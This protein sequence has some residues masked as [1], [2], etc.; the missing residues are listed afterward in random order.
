ME[1][2]SEVRVV[3]VFVDPR[4]SIKVPRMRFQN[5]IISIFLIS[6]AWFLHEENVVAFTPNAPLKSSGVIGVR[7]Q[8]N[9]QVPTRVFQSSKSLE[10]TGG[11]AVG[12]ETSC[13]LSK[14]EVGSIITRN[15]GT[16]KEKRLNLYGISIIFVSLLTC[17]IWALAMAITNKINE[18]FPDLDPTRSF[19][20]TT[21]KIWSKAFL[22]LAGSFPTVSGDIDQLKVR[23]ERG[24]AC[25]YVANHAS[26]LDIPVLCTVLHPVFKFI[27]KGELGKL[28]CIGQQLRGVRSLELK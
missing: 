22:T 11:P 14:E 5:H 9:R 20:D 21:G 25:L 13:V 1:N 7:E 4:P 24:E 8:G 3:S 15:E 17:P 27:A 23:E 28:P 6:C 19:Y 18:A 16:A 2:D 12:F 26:W 10:N